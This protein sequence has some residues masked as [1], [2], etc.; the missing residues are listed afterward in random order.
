MTETRPAFKIWMESDEG[1]VFGPGV[2]S[3]L[4]KVEETGTLKDAAASL[5]M[6]YRF[7][8]GLVKRAEA[9]LGRPLM[10]AHKGGRAGGGGTQLTELGMQF[11]EDFSKIERLISRIS[12]DGTLLI[13][14]DD[15][16]EVEGTVQELSDADDSFVVTIRPREPLRLRF[17]L[18]KGKGVRIHP[19]K[20]DRLT[21]ELIPVLKTASGRRE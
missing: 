12:E 9:K 19:I 18:P 14:T 6:S 16:C 5:N 13:D 1:Y 20:G 21:F 17:K 15:R 11:M 10:A 7:A 3:I 2:Y 4:R 8:W